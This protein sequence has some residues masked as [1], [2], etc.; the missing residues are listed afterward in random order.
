MKE[1]EVRSLGKPLK[2]TPIELKIEEYKLKMAKA[3]GDRNEIEVTLGI[4]SESIKLIILGL[5]YFKQLIVRP[6]SMCYFAKNVMKFLDV[7]F[8]PCFLY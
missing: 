1:Q 2:Q 3:E 4:Q 7:F 5:G 8:I 6:L